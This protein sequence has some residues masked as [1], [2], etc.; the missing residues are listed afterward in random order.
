MS[1]DYSLSDAINALGRRLWAGQWTGQESEAR[2]VQDPD[3]IRQARVPFEAEMVELNLL[4]QAKGAER[5]EA[6]SK[7][8]LDRINSDLMEIER[9][10]QELFTCLNEVGMVRK[11][12]EEDHARWERFDKTEAELLRAFREGELFVFGGNSSRV[13]PRLWIEVPKGFGWNWALS[14][15]FWPPD[16]SARPV[17]AGKIICAEFEDWLARQLPVVEGANVDQLPAEQRF[18]L[19][20]RKLVKAGPKPAPRDKMKRDAMREFPGL[21][22]RAFQRVWDKEAPDSWTKSGKPR[23]KR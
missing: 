10:Q 9:R 21:S 23:K 12:E 11:F 3:V 22:G 14:L 2:K 13:E 5:R 8:A 17:D 16:K 4:R 18:T 6:V 7:D 20:F 15:I 19:H 1:R